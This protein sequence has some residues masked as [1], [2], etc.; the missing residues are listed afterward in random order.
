MSPE[1]DIVVLAAERE[2]P[3]QRPPLSKG[4]L[5]GTVSPER[6][7]LRAREGAY[8]LRSGVEAT[9]L[10]LDRAIVSTTA[11]QER[12]DRLLIATG[13]RPRMLAGFAPGAR[14]VYLRTLADAIR[15]RG[16]LE[17]ARHCSVIGGGFIGLEVAASARERGLAVT[18][19]EA[20]KRL[21]PRAV[22]PRASAEVEANQRALDVDVRL[23]TTAEWIDQDRGI[24]RVGEE[25][26]ATDVVVVGVGV[27]PALEWLG[28]A[29]AVD[30]VL[31][32]TA[33]ASGMVTEDGTIAVAGDA[34]AWWHPR[35]GRHLRFEHFETAATQGAR[36]AENLLRSPGEDLDDLPF[37]WSDQ[38]PLLLQVLGAPDAD[39]EERCD[40]VADGWIFTYHR[41]SRIEGAVLMNAPGELLA[42]KEAMERSL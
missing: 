26:L 29:L 32:L 19:V 40:E 36:A 42:V 14:V 18:V 35:F 9:G 16:L 28:D 33:T 34:G 24:L 17:G 15:L 31:G 10:D 30:P 39:L 3:Y 23:A 7:T 8:E 21:L 27:Q 25:E 1:I 20:A 41:D 5:L 4:F 22:G 6:V 38:G 2:R 37:G 13:A 12:Y 11:G